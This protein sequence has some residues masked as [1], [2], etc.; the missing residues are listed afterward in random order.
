MR[1]LAR[2]R[3]L[4]DPELSAFMAAVRERRHKH[5]PRDHAFFALLANTGIRPSEALA[6]TRADVHVHAAPPW[7]RVHRLKRAGSPRTD[8]LQV[9]PAVA[10]SMRTHLDATPAGPVFGMSRRQ[11]QRLF[12]YYAR[13]AGIRRPVRLYILRHTAATRL[14]AASRD[15]GLVQAALGH[16]SPDTTAIYAHVPAAVLEETANAVPS[17]V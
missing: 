17:F 14:Y 2:D 8:E 12:H 10:E 9:T 3:F 5:R 1:Q 4:S 16:V 6:L 13:R 15:I 7:I 11:A